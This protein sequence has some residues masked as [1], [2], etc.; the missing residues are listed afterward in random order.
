[1][2]YHTFIENIL[3]VTFTQNSCAPNRSKRLIVAFYLSRRF[4]TSGMLHRVFGLRRIN[5][6]PSKRGH[7]LPQGHGLAS[8]QT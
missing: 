5:Y 8:Q 1:M 3:D 2:S 7:L 4:K 6:D